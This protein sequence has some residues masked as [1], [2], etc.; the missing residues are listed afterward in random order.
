[1]DDDTAKPSTDSKPSSKAKITD[2]PETP[3]I[4]R[5][6][7]PPRNRHLEL[8]DWVDN[9]IWDTDQPIAAKV[10]KAYQEL[11]IDPSDPY[12]LFE[13]ER[14]EEEEEEEEEE[15]EEEKQLLEE[16]KVPFVYSLSVFLSLFLFLFLFPY[17]LFFLL[18]SFLI[19]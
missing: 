9:I 12:I 18:F 6:I 15:A 5:S 1:V 19:S 3:L 16:E 4:E 7:L 8:G 14:E 10:L 11:Q 2:L 13:E 17:S